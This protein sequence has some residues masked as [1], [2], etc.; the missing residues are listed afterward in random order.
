MKTII[1]TMVLIF[2]FPTVSQHISAAT[3]VNP[4]PERTRTEKVSVNTM[5][6]VNES[7]FAVINELH[8]NEPWGEAVCTITQTGAKLR[9][10]M[11][12]TFHQ[13]R[14]TFVSGGLTYM[15]MIY[16]VGEAGRESEFL[17]VGLERTGMTKTNEI[18]LDIDLLN[19]DYECYLVAMGGGVYEAFPAPVPEVYQLKS[20]SQRI[21]P[22]G[23]PV[24]VKYLDEYGQE[25]RDSQI[26]EGKAKESYDVTTA[27]YRPNIEGYTL[28]T[29]KLPQ[30]A[31][32]EFSLNIENIVTYVY[33]NNV[34]HARF[35]S[36]FGR[37]RIRLQK[38]N[39]GKE[40][41]IKEGISFV[42][43]GYNFYGWNT[44]SDGSGVF[45][46]SSQKLKNLTKENYGVVDLYAQWKAS[47]QNI[48]F[49]ANGGSTDQQRITDKTDTM[50]D[51][52]NVKNASRSGYFFKGWYTNKEGGT[53]IPTNI[54]M[55]A[56]GV[57]YY[58]QWEGRL[59]FKEVPE[60]LS[61]NESKIS[62]RTSETLRT[63]PNWKM[64]VEDTRVDKNPW[65]VT[66]KLVEPFKNSSGESATGNILLFRKVNASD[67]W[68][69]K[70][71]ETNVFDGTSTKGIDDYNVSWSQDS[72]PIIQ[73]APGT[74]K[75]G[76]YKGVVQ[77]SLTDAPV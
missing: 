19:A 55:P 45:Y 36:N 49:D 33:T 14:T 22:W 8:I 56:G 10:E 65:R 30:N 62:N 29:N 57:T 67:Q 3:L 44:S 43:P 50:V 66:A 47:D 73:V 61:F 28:D 68:I 16:R 32:G 21:V 51:L 31:K 35:H 11:K 24:K 20:T 40:V 60:I 58:A 76:E 18:D 5:P 42:R 12:G 39:Y 15:L 54:S 37:D 70:S 7:D 1:I 75:A 27:A 26:V 23:K 4:K 46:S 72:G 6:K 64:I 63:N 34:Y 2:F 17:S 53:K 9:A 59:S 71:E 48:T 74:V 52:S 13:T 77:W 69:T 38:I 25:I 41:A